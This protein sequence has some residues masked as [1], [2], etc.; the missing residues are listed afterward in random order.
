M[1]TNVKAIRYT[2]IPR[3]KK[4]FPNFGKNLAI[5]IFSDKRMIK[6]TAIVI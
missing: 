5:T 4:F 1:T 3:R 2:A 6:D